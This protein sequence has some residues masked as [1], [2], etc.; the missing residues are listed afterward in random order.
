MDSQRKT[1]DKLL[2]IIKFIFAFCCGQHMHFMC[3]Q[4]MWICLVI[5]CMYHYQGKALTM[6][7]VHLNIFSFTAGI[8]IRV[9][10][11][12]DIFET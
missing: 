12:C 6:E 10:Q 3:K 9:N 11:F 8:T 1:G 7:Y 4:I 2:T 5:V